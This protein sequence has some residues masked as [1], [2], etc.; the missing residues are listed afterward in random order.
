MFVRHAGRA[1]LVVFLPFS[2]RRGDA[3]PCGLR[4]QLDA[5]CVVLSSLPCGAAVPQTLVASLQ[6]PLPGVFVPLA[7]PQSQAGPPPRP[8]AD[9][10]I[11][12]EAKNEALNSRD[13]SPGGRQAGSGRVRPGGKQVTG[14]C[15]APPWVGWWTSG[16]AGSRCS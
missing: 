2:S 15:R 6:M 9:A 13:L 3:V 5:V 4:A 10:G 1:A 16:S 12:H 7:V 11:Q 14:T 8:P